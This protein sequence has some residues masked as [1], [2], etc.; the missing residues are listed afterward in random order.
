[1]P[2]QHKTPLLGWH[3]PAKLLARIRAE[4][5]RRGITLAA[6]LSEAALAHLD[7]HEPES[8]RTSPGDQETGK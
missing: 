8:L 2:S 4:V 1:M 6:W 3:P 7:H 5:K